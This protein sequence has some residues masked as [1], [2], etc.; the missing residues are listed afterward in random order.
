MIVLTRM[1]KEQLRVDRLKNYKFINTKNELFF[2]RTA[3]FYSQLFKLPFSA[4][5]LVDEDQQRFKSI[6]NREEKKSG[7]KLSSCSIAIEN[8]Y[9]IMLFEDAKKKTNLKTI[10]LLNP[11]M[12]D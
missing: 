6:A 4:V 9:Q 8:P 5:T 7:R 11:Y 10:T 2:N 3:E 12:R 1:E